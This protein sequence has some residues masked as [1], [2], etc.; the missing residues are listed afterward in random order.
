MGGRREGEE[1]EGKGRREG[2]EEEGEGRREGEE[3]EGGGRGCQSS[4]SLKY[5]TSNSR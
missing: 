2:E 5:H 1:E 3:E 4:C